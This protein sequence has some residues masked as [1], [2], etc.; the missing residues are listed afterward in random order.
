[1]K[2]AVEEIEACK[3]RLQVE[4]P[5]EIVQK[6]WEEAYGR[7]Q[8]QARLPGFRRGHV[9]RSL[10]KLHFADEVRQEVARR[11]IPE[12]YRQALA[13]TKLRPVEEPDF[14]DVTLEEG[15]SLKFTAVME[16][17]PAITLGQY[18]GLALQRAPAHATDEEVE[19][20]LCRL[21]EQQAEF[22]V[23]E[24]AATAGDLVIIDY[25]LAP[26]GMEP[27]SEQ[28][29]AFLVESEGILTEINEAVKG[30]ASGGEREV[31]VRFPES[32]QREDLRGKQGVA[33]VRVAEVKEKILPPL[34]DGFARALGE[35]DSLDALR[36]AIKKE[37]EG[38]R[39]RE[40]RRALEE[41][42]VD[43]LLAGHDFQIPEALVL[44]HVAYLI[45]SARERIRQSGGDPDRISWDYGK[46]AD[47]LR[48][49]ADRAVRRALLL[50]VI[51]EREGL[52]PSDADIEAEVER[53]AQASR[54]PAPAVHRLLEKSGELDG[55][56]VSL[57]EAR[58][59]DF[60]IEHAIVQ[61][62]VH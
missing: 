18:T 38:R 48:P 61:T 37:M 11:L 2:V 34:D 20:T 62:D 46:L 42:T 16:I 21:R 25:T 33:R 12:V 31:R 35:Y 53:I 7:I 26:E 28:G 15:S 29:Y 3:R 58:A 49:A 6:A 54:R 24:R 9:P 17:K 60:L 19:E 8:R 55:L 1:M 50:E 44:R 30:L 10:V 52:T 56:R 32:H 27:K 41:K 43:A 13:E 36:A 39:E 22:R 4:A 45:E 57:R 47:E 14:K 51:A 23:V 5:E 59:L 40:A